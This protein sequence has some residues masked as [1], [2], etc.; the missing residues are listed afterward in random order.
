[1]DVTANE[2]EDSASERP[3]EN[4][5]WQHPPPGRYEFWVENNNDRNENVTTVRPSFAS[6]SIS[7]LRPGPP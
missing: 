4:M 6:L 1:M 3:V 2:D 5:Y 7:W